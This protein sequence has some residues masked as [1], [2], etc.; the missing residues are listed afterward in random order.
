M[1][2]S[3]EVSQLESKPEYKAI[4][5]FEAHAETN[6][7]KAKP[8]TNKA[9]DPPTSKEELTQPEAANEFNSSDSFFETGGITKQK[10]IE[11]TIEQESP[12]QQVKA[13][14]EQTNE[15]ATRP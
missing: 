6:E 8:S 5:P 12:E 15:A 11:K 3:I 14:K 7:M 13:P 1:A 2:P 4:E 9:A 10:T